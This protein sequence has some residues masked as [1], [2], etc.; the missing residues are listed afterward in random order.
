VERLLEFLY[1]GTYS[2]GVTCG[3]QETDTKSSVQGSEQE[4]S[5][6]EEQNTPPDNDVAAGDENNELPMETDGPAVHHQSEGSKRHADPSDDM[7]LHLRLY[8]IAVKYKVPALQTLALDRFCHAVELIW[9]DAERF[10]AMVDELYD[11]MPPRGAVLKETLCRLV[12]TAI[13]DQKVRRKLKA[14][15]EKHGEFAFGVMDYAIKFGPG[16]MTEMA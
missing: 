16:Q 1:T 3:N 9:K 7:T 13:H 14:V 4:V 10:P 5:G 15:F 6:D 11:T 2:D 12:G 8:L